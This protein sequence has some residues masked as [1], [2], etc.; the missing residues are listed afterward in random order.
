MRHYA[1][2]QTALEIL[3]QAVRDNQ[4]HL[5]KL[6]SFLQQ[7]YSSATITVLAR[8]TTLQMTDC[9]AVSCEYCMRAEGL[10]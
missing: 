6:S 10:I 8:K 4:H 2:R 3:G 5:N 1:G 7:N 9:V